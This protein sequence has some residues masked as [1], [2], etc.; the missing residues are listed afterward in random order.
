MN[1]IGLTAV[2]V[3]P[4]I[5]P[6]LP[7]A[8]WSQSWSH[9]TASAPTEPN[10]VSPKNSVPTHLTAGATPRR[11]TGIASEAPGHVRPALH[12]KGKAVSVSTFGGAGGQILRTN[13][14]CTRDFY[15]RVSSFNQP[16]GR[17]EMR[18]ED[19]LQR[20]VAGV[21]TSESN[22]SRRRID[23]QLKFN[24]VTILS[25]DDRPRFRS[26]FGDASRRL[27][28]TVG[29]GPIKYSMARRRFSRS[30]ES[31]TSGNSPAFLATGTPG[32]FTMDSRQFHP[33]RELR[34]IQASI[35]Q[36]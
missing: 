11:V 32:E 2:R 15:Q 30:S 8:P 31:H 17:G 16:A 25:G 6:S 9:R 10:A 24:E 7:A 34:I 14:I 22:D 21:A 12:C 13:G 4:G 33:C 20:G 26:P 29:S 19:L 23:P 1:P 27:P 36:S 5:A 35:H 18:G 3:L 28:A